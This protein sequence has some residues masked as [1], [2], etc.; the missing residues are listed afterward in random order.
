MSAAHMRTQTRINFIKEHPHTFTHSIFTYDFLN[1]FVS[2]I[3]GS[4][5]IRIKKILNERYLNGL[6]IYIN[7]YKLIATDNVYLSKFAEYH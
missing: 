4:N 3:F 6:K 2:L 1:Y 7:T 5:N